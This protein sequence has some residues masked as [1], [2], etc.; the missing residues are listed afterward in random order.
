M[1]IP[2]LPGY[3]TSLGGPEYKGLI[4]SL[5]TITAMI[6]RPFSGKLADSIGR[7]PV[8]MVGSLVCFVCSLLYPLLATVSGFLFLRLFH[9][10]STG[11]K[12]TG[13]A[14]YLSDVIPADR[15]GE[16]M[17]FLGTAGSV[18]MAGGPAVGGLITNQF[19]LNFMFYCSAAFA[20]LSAVMTSAINET[21]PVKKPFS[22]SILK[23]N[24]RDLFDRRVLTP[25]VV[26]LLLVYSYGSVFT[27][28][29]DFGEHVGI[30]NNGLLFT[31][32]T[33][34]SL[35]VRLVGGKASDM[36]GRKPVLQ[37]CAVVVLLSMIVIAFANS[38]L[39][40][41]FGISLYGLAQGASSPTLL[42]WATDLS[43]PKAKG[44]GVASLYIFMEF[45]I[46]V[47][48]FASGLIYANDPS[49]FAVSFLICAFFA[50]TALVYLFTFSRLRSPK[51]GMR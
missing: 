26:M 32:M 3:I 42:A 18:G 30:R 31:Y 43:D 38:Q 37:V 9:G 41:I 16:A 49:R 45:G 28:I 40:L 5:F 4:I 22:I 19:G 34:A 2:E 1:L 47:G 36:W 23:V 6:S 44:R 27:L 25:C 7:V 14:A 15:K 35:L 11:F 51:P 20:L 29:P 50:G 10:F 39:Q 13:Q 21:L 33:L 24:R 17:G 46:G 48:A 12:P 8:M